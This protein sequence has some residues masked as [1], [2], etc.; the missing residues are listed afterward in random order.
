[1]KYLYKIFCSRSNNISFLLNLGYNK[2]MSKQN[3]I[4]IDARF[5]ATAGPGRY[6]KAIIEHLEKI[7][8]VNKYVVFLRRPGYSSYTPKNP[9]FTKIL[10]DYPWYSWSEQILFLAKILKFKPDLL[11]VPH[12]NIPIFFPGKLVTAIPDLIMHIFST[13]AGTTLWKPYFRF[14]KMIYR[15]VVLIAVLRTYKNICPSQ[16][17]KNDFIKYYPFVN[18]DKFMVSYEG[19]DPDLLKVPTDKFVK[20]T[21]KKYNIET[22]FL[23]YVSSMYEHKNVER[24]VTAFRILVNE[25]DY[26]GSLVLIGKK[27]KFSERI[28]NL[29]RDLN[30]EDKVILPGLQSFVNDEEVTAFRKS[31]DLYVFPS[32]KEGFSL[33]PLEAQY[34]GLPCVISDIPCHREIYGDSVAYFNPFKT[35]EISSSINNI[36]RDKSIQKELVKKG[37]ANVEKYNWINTAH[38]TLTVFKQVLG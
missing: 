25:Y 3:L 11:Y 37:R 33:T 19:V 21:L 6:T 38:D 1:M 27:D 36:L 18:K 8:K 15:L 32:L 29:V 12:F 13:E 4:A 35:N 17:V 22:P 7:D 20:D 2:H 31:A 10:A 5:F 34:Y 16:D 9:N 23:L 14:K 26:K 30:L 24:L 28:L